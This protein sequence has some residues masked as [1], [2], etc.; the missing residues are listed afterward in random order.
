MNLRVHPKYK[1]VLKHRI[2]R[3]R[4]QLGEELLGKGTVALIGGHAPTPHG[5]VEVSCDR[6]DV[7]PQHAMQAHDRRDAIQLDCRDAEA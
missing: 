2:S 4:S 1:G 7:H 5:S 3:L 6:F